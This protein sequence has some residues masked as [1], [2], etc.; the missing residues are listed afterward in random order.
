MYT[1]WKYLWENGRNIY[2]NIYEKMVEIFMEIFM[3]KQQKYLWT[4]ECW[5]NDGKSEAERDNNPKKLQ[6]MV[7]FCIKIHF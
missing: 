2:G 6:Q 4:D 3:G 1:Q 5:A 7:N